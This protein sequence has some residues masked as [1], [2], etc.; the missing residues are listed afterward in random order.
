MSG[1]IRL[2]NLKEEQL[3]PLEIWNPFPTAA[4]K[5]ILYL[6]TILKELNSV[7]QPVTG[8]QIF[9]AIKHKIMLNADQ[10]PLYEQLER[11]GSEGVT[12]FL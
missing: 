12:L 1:S 4:G 5:V 9:N 10:T 6:H 7:D 11:V 2:F 3:W 8:N